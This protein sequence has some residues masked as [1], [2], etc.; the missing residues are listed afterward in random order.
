MIIDGLQPQNIE[1]FT[2]LIKNRTSVNS[3][4]KLIYA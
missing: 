4:W 2:D 1:Y 3:I